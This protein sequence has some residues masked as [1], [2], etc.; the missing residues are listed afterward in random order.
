MAKEKEDKPIELNEAESAAITVLEGLFGDPNSDALVTISAAHF[1]VLLK[2]APEFEEEDEIKA[3]GKL[4]MASK[5]CSVLFP[6]RKRTPDPLAG[7]PVK[8]PANKP[9][10]QI[11]DET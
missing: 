3:G 1:N 6:L 7:K 11:N 2:I 9:P 8:M 5:V 10:K 4:V